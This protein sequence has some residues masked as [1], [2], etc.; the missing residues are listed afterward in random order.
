MVLKCD[1]QKKKKKKPPHF[2]TF[3]PSIFNFNPFPP[4]FLASF[5]P[6]GQQKL[7]SQRSLPPCPACYAT[8]YGYY[9]A[10]PSCIFSQISKTHTNMGY[11]VT[12][13]VP[14]IWFSISPYLQL[15]YQI[16]T[17]TDIHKMLIICNF[18]G[19]LHPYPKI[20]MFCVLSQ[21]INTDTVIIVSHIL[22]KMAPVAVFSFFGP[23]ILALCIKSV[24][25]SIFC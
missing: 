11:S 5:F 17:K 22:T 2:V 20:S 10:Q 23:I 19:V 14:V 8:D 18:K 7:S 13:H 6:V 3:P 21:T 16:N 12:N 9:I 4:F 25:V 15:C 24:T 1:K